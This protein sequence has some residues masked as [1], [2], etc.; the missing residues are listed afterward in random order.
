MEKL[1][2][3]FPAP[4]LARLRQVAK[5]SDRPVSELVRA[6]VDA[7]LATQPASPAVV[8]E[9]PPVYG[10]GELRIDPAALREAAWED[11]AQP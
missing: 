2:I 8:R 3:L 5:Q 7:W 9:K 11:R 6:A 1:Q 4:Q 10:L